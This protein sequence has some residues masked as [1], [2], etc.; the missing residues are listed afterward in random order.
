MSFPPICHPAGVSSP[1]LTK[2]LQDRLLNNVKELKSRR[3]GKLELDACLSLPGEAPSV[4]SKV[5]ICEVIQNHKNLDFYIY[6]NPKYSTPS[7][8]CP[9]EVNASLLSS[10]DPV[11]VLCDNLERV[12]IAGEDVIVSGGR[13]KR[14]KQGTKKTDPSPL[15]FRCQCAKGYVGDKFDFD[16]GQVVGRDDYRVS[17]ITNDAKNKRAGSKGRHGSHRTDTVR[18]LSKDELKCP[19]QFS[20]SKNQFGYYVKTK[21]GVPYHEFHEPRPFLRMP[22]RLVEA[23]EATIVQDIHSAKAMTGVAANTHY[24]RTSRKGTPT[25]L[26][27]DQ[28]RYI[29][30]KH[31][32]GTNE[33]KSSDDKTK[34]ATSGLDDLFAY[35]EESGSSYVTLL[36]RVKTIDGNEQGSSMTTKESYLFN[37]KY[38]GSQTTKEDY[39]VESS[40]DDDAL[41]VVN[42]NCARRK[43]DDNQ[44]M[45]VSVAY[46]TPFELRQF[47]LFHCVIQID[48]TA[49]SNNEGRPLVTVTSKDSNGKMFTLLRAF[50]ANQQAWSFKWLFQVVFPVLL[51]VDTLN[52]VKI[53]LAD[54]DPQQISQLEDAI[55]KYFPHMY[56]TRCS[57]HIIDRGWTSK[58]NLKLGG[59][60]RRKRAKIKKG[61]PR[62]KSDPL[63][64]VNKV[65]RK[66]YRWMFSWAQADHCLSLQEFH[67]DCCFC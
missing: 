29:C 32:K 5:N 6:L 44:E 52:N 16:S 66:L 46:V 45:V 18:C 34:D 14:Q 62:K 59:K 42:A 48:A 15:Y 37:E 43:I 3:L 28:I 8:H 1:S 63:S 58:V 47:Q 20:V 12:A 39:V 10:S 50:L 33:N 55:D 67:V 40:V 54:G 38:I 61:Q 25:L 24:V 13:G 49:D 27:N 21:L 56:R 23:K 4:Y 65:A 41:K 36:Q 60:S 11:D 57:W 26:S 9:S 17:T 64:E 22:S 2:Q 19:F 7:V 30:R 51:G 31:V 53:A 35:L